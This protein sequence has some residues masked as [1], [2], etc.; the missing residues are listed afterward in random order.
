MTRED[1]GGD[2]LEFCERMWYVWVGWKVGLAVTRGVGVGEVDVG[3]VDG[4]KEGRRGDEGLKSL[5]D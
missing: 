2:V 3:V 5:R 1:G 4:D